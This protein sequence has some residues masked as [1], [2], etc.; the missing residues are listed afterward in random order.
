MP[1]QLCKLCWRQQL[2][3]CSHVC[4]PMHPELPIF[5]STNNIDA[6]QPHTWQM[7][8]TPVPERLCA[9]TDSCM[10]VNFVKQVPAHTW[11]ACRLLLCAEE[12]ASLSSVLMSVSAAS[13]CGNRLQKISMLSVCS[14]CIAALQLATHMCQVSVDQVCIQSCWC[15]PQNAPRWALELSNLMCLLV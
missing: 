12:P 1:A 4:L 3:N 11:V 10:L 15:V 7:F 14:C 2:C 6:V 13:F 5:Q 8:H 9:G